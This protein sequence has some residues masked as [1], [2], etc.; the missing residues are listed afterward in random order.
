MDRIVPRLSWQCRRSS[1]ADPPRVRANRV[2]RTTALPAPCR[3]AAVRVNG[4]RRTLSCVPNRSLMNATGAAFCNQIASALRMQES[5]T[6]WKLH[7]K[8]YGCNRGQ[9]AG[10]RLR[11]I[12]AAVDHSGDS[13]EWCLVY[14]DH[15]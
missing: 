14:T 1:G 9:K 6:A 12:A 4:D 3:C 10:K 11:K 7:L 5:V 13:K 8:W 2:E 15:V